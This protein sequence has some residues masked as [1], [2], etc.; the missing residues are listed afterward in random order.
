MNDG[1]NAAAPA[2]RREAAGIGN[3]MDAQPTRSSI[4]IRRRPRLIANAAIF[5]L[6]LILARL[7]ASRLLSVE[8]PGILSLWSFATAGALGLFTGLIPKP[9]RLR[10][11]ASAQRALGSPAATII[12]AIALFLALLSCGI[13]RMDI[14]WSG[15]TMLSPEVNGTARTLSS[16][17]IDNGYSSAS[18]YMPAYRMFRFT[19]GGY[20]FEVRPNP[21][22]VTA[23]NVPFSA[24]EAGPYAEIEK[25]LLASFFQ[26]FEQREIDEAQRQIYASEP[27]T[28]A[29]KAMLKRLQ[30][31]H[32]AEAAVFI[33]MSPEM[34][35]IRAH[36]IEAAYPQDPWPTLILAG[37]AYAAKHY[38]DCRNRLSDSYLQRTTALAMPEIELAGRFFRA[39]CSLKEGGTALDLKRRRMLDLA[40][41]DF[42]VAEQQSRSLADGDFRDIALPSSIIFQAICDF[43]SGRFDQSVE[44]FTRAFEVGRPDLR[45]R[46]L[47]GAGYAK[48][49]A[50]DTYQA[51][52]YLNQALTVKP[53]FPYA[54]SNYG[55]VLMSDKSKYDEARNYFLANV[56]DPDLQKNSPR[57][58]TLAK[59]S[60]AHLLE[61][62][63]APLA[64]V[65]ASYADIAHKI[66][67]N[68]W[69]GIVPN[70]LR[71]G[72]L[73][74]ELTNRVYLSGQYYAVEIFALTFLCR[75]KE[76]VAPL[77]ESSNRDAVQLRS[78]LDTA[79]VK[80]RREVSPAWLEHP[81]SGWFSALQG[82]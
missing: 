16:R 15:P 33:L 38:G 62:Q 7:S 3:T 34:G 47:N 6:A 64:K 39:V 75:A 22:S 26:F 36:N 43:Y 74:R 24:T 37:S 10:L 80:L 79:I 61:L 12:G 63:G 40:R 72:Y 68:A 52:V 67:V 57:D 53:N 25:G 81:G 31:I 28:E 20:E 56:Q 17:T 77:S 4:G 32:D 44:T 21:L 35:S 19:V 51:A 48:F 49:V 8:L 23:I 14:R 71:Y 11:L 60:V 13:S 18:L 69:D 30:A 76:R 45:A 55:Y 58:I 42:A 65:I 54:R 46:A 78:E 59:L 82:C 9:T 73:A 50:G 70:G 1:G 2:V 29:N 41:R 66:H 27:D 5:I